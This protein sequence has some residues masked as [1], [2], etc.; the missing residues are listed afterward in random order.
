[1]RGVSRRYGRR[2]ALIDVSFTVP[3]GKV[4]M[5]AGRNGSGKSTLLRVLSTAIRPDLGTA[6][7]EGFDLKHERD[8][9]RRKV[10]IL[11]HASYT[12]DEL[13]AIENLQLMARLVGVDSSREAMLHLLNQ[14]GLAERAED[15]IN[16]FSA[17]MRKRI[18]L[19]RVLLQKATVVMLD[20]PYGQLDP[21]GFR[22]IDGMVRHL[23]D[24]GVTLLMATHQLERASA[25][26]DLGI[27]LDRG[28][29]TW[30]GAAKD[31]PSEGGLEPAGT[32]EG[33]P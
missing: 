25:L 32:P 6:K 11:G 1:M 22:F 29:L 9:V 33:G 26:C 17:G 5:V 19:A 20:E 31:L 21:P 13:S 23:R 30:E 4:V 2:W 18:S 28:R 27:V 14:V 12:Y 8:D 24:E 16:T 3:H 15:S 7:I 10:A